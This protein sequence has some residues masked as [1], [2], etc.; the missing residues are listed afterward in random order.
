MGHILTRLFL[1]LLS[2]LSAVWAT[3][4]LANADY[5]VQLDNLANRIMSGDGFQQR[6]LLDSAPLLAAAE[7]RAVC[8]PRE[9]RAAAIVRLRLFEEAMNASNTHLADQ[10]LRLLRTSVDLALGCVPTEGFLW[11][12]R[13]WSAI[14]AGSP[15]GEHFD[16]LRRSYVLAP[17]D[18]WIALRRN[19]YALSIYEILPDDIRRMA[20]DELLAIVASGFVADAAKTIQGPGWAIRDQWLPRLETVRLDIR[21]R[22]D[23]ALRD[24]GLNVD[25]PGVGAREF[26]PWQ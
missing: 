3:S 23:K 6:P 26:R 14:N 1:G 24:E 16:E 17:F 20:L 9:I 2:S 21:I 15:A 13:Y 5:S 22:L 12:V 8:N 7:A 4:F 19:R 25:I 18:G 11:F 10:R